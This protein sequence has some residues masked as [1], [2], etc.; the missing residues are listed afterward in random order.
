MGNLQ[1][2]WSI[3]YNEHGDV[4]GTVMI[5]SGSLDLT[6]LHLDNEDSEAHHFHQYDYQYDSQGNWTE[7]I[8]KA[9]EGSWSPATHRKLTYY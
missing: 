5:Q 6:Q 9:I 2:D 3:T 7:K 4:A 1:Q 8:Y